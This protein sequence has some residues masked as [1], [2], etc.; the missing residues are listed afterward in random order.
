MFIKECNEGF[1]YVAGT[2]LGSLADIDSSK[3]KSEYYI[4][5]VD[6]FFKAFPQYKKP[7]SI[8]GG[9]QANN[10]NFLNLTAF[11]FN[12]VPKEIYYVQWEGT[13]FISV[14]FSYDLERQEEISEY[15]RDKSF[16]EQQEKN[17]IK[18]RFKKEV[19][20]RI[21]SLINISKDR[22]SAIYKPT[23]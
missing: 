12:K 6:T 13:G 16:V 2:G 9:N 17:R 3:Y 14:R 11:Y 19:L 21:D 22:D 4:K 7:D 8:F 20:D 23:F 18:N 10:Y 5:Y 15:P 1:G